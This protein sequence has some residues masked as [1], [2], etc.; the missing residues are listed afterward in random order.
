V[1]GGLYVFSITEGGERKKERGLTERIAKRRE[2]SFFE[3]L[4][5]GEETR[6]CP[7]INLGKGDDFDLTGTK[8]GK[9]KRVERVVSQGVD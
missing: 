4:G 9:G 6:M 1:R 3:K 2:G 7:T 8:R 5:E